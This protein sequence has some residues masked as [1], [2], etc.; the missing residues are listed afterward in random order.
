MK[1]ILLR[2]LPSGNKATDP[3]C[4]MYVSKDTPNGGTFEHNGEIFYFCAPG[5]R[6]AFSKEPQEYLSGNKHIDM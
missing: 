6:V 2:M 1:N 4:G 3:V 5:C